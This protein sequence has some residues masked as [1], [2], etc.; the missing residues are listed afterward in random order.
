ME[1]KQHA[2]KIPVGQWENKREIQKYLEIYD[3]EN[4]V[5]NLWDA[6]KAVLGGKF[7][8][9]RAFLKKKKNI[10]STT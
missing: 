6:A 1:T 8:A 5:Q 3:N 7:I 10:N 2:T 4:T 9:I